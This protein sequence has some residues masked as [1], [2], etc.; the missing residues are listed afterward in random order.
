MDRPI[1]EWHRDGITVQIMGYADGLST[2][3]RIIYARVPHAWPYGCSDFQVSVG[4][5]Y[6]D[7]SEDLRSFITMRARQIEWDRFRGRAMM[8]NTP[9]PPKPKPTW[10]DYLP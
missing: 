9:P 7:K 3:Q 1:E 10:R 4:P 5:A 8:G 2:T 6:L